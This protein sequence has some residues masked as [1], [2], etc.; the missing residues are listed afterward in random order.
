MKNE[1]TLLHWDV[2]VSHLLTEPSFTQA[3]ERGKKG[4]GR[5]EVFICPISS[6]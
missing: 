3:P 5:E 1:E 2:F 4:E 6:L